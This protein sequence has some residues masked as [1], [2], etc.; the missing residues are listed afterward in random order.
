VFSTPK[1]GKLCLDLGIHI[2]GMLVMFDWDMG[3]VN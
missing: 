3:D 1:M 2:F